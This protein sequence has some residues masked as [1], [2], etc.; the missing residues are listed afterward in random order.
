MTRKEIQKQENM[1]VEKEWKLAKPVWFSQSIEVDESERLNRCQAF[2]YKT[3]G[4]SF[5]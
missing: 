2:W 5:W 1:L 4:M 3:G